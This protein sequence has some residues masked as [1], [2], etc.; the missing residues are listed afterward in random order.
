MDSLTAVAPTQ[1]L[2][3]NDRLV[4]VG[5]VESVVDLQKMRGL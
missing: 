2:F 3:D 5:N 1:K 4:F